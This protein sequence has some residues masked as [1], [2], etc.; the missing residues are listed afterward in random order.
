MRKSA[1]DQDTDQKLEAA[2]AANAKDISIL[3]ELQAQTKKR[4]GRRKMNVAR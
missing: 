2:V 4:R 1:D 3:S